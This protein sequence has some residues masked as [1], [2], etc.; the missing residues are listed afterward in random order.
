[1]N[2]TFNDKVNVE[3]KKTSCKKTTTKNILSNTMALKF[4]TELYK[5]SSEETGSEILK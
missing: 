2:I 1:M 5:E 4:I 3:H